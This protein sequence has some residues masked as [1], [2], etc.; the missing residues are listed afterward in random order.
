MAACSAGWWGGQAG[1][2][3]VPWDRREAWREWDAR[4]ALSGGWTDEE[5]GRTAV[6]VGSARFPTQNL[7]L[8]AGRGP[9]GPP[10]PAFHSNSDPFHPWA[11]DS[12]ASMNLYEQPPGTGGSQPMWPL[13]PLWDGFKESSFYVESQ[14][15]SLGPAWCC[16]APSHSHMALHR[17]R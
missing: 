10:S 11:G 16:P 13:V 2:R 14:C 12:P 15:A 4:R 7:R 9:Q 1:G 6:S 3:H 8:R 17:C 5:G